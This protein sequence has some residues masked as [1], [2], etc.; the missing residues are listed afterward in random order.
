MKRIGLYLGFP[1]EGGG[2]FQYAQSVLDALLN[3]PPSRYEILVAYSHTAW[4]P[5]LQKLDSRVLKI[6]THEGKLETLVRTALRFG[7]PLSI[8]R[9]IA[10]YVHPFTRQLM[11]QGCD[12]WLFPAQDVWTYAIPSPTLGVIHDLMHRYER[13]FPE[14]SAFG[15]FHRRERHYRRL[16][17]HA[18][19]VLV[20]SEVGKQQ[21]LESYDIRAEHIHVLPYVAPAYMRSEYVPD[22]FDKRYHLPPKFLFY[23]AQFW[24]HKN[25]CRLLRALAAIRPKA[26]DLHLILAGSKKNA[27]PRVLEEIQRLGLEDRVQI[28]GYIPDDDVPVF[29]RRARALVMPTFFGPTNIPPLEAIAAGC[30]LAVSNIYAMPAQVGNAALLFDPE[31]V[32]EIAQALLQ[33]AGS[34]ELCVRLAEAGKAKSLRWGQVQFN[35]RFQTIVESIVGK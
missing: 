2:A 3:L 7:L 14:V 32:E 35:K 20:D 9:N 15:L 30:P 5:K 27:Y 6:A 18:K 21:V 10:K 4:S 13:R 22:D 12:L 25:H 23:P 26:P 24:E 29:Y 8:W 31:S 1:P 17:R 19:G 33:L 34:D 11:D 16:C 28:L